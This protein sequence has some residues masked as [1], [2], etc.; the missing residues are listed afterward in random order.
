MAL[1]E[2]IKLRIVTDAA[3]SKKKKRMLRNLQEMGYR[4]GYKTDLLIRV[5]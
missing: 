2:I 3:D 4:Y 1:K 5:K